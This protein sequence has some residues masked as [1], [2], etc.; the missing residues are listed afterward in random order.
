[1]SGRSRGLRKLAAAFHTAWFSCKNNTVHDESIVMHEAG[2][3]CSSFLPP[4]RISNSHSPAWVLCSN[5]CWLLFPPWE[6]GPYEEGTTV[7]W[8]QLNAP[9]SEIYQLFY[10]WSTKHRL[11]FFYSM[12]PST[13]SFTL[14]CLGLSHLFTPSLLSAG[15]PRPHSRLPPHWHEPSTCLFTPLPVALILP[16]L[17]L[18]TCS[19]G[20]FMLSKCSH[21]PYLYSVR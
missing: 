3:L 15:L 6:W 11:P 10:K 9:T 14:I 2:V 13:S 17:C 20:N 4:S 5:L 7:W 1:M 19:Q 16:V 18:L 21:I 8:P 12:L